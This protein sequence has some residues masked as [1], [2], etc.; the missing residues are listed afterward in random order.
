MLVFKH[1]MALVMPWYVFGIP[2][3]SAVSEHNFSVSDTADTKR[4]TRLA[5]KSMDSLLFLYS[6]LGLMCNRF[7]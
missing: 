5:A 1:S 6:N 3:S 2:A 4:G 7:S